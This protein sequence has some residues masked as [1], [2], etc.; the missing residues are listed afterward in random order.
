MN[1]QGSE[2]SKYDLF[3]SNFFCHF[4]TLIFQGDR[5]EISE[6][7]NLALKIKAMPGISL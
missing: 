2:Q 6:I 1:G 5:L 3:P 4:I 7:Y